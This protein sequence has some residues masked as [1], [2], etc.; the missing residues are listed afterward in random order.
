MV[1]RLPPRFSD[2]IGSRV[3]FTMESP[4]GSSQCRLA[5]GSASSPVFLRSSCVSPFVHRSGCQLL[6]SRRPLSSFL[7]FFFFFFFFLFV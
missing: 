7:S 4:L 1:H 6:L 5:F 3:P 2:S